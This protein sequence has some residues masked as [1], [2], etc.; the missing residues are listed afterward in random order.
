[1][2]NS[3]KTREMTP[4]ENFRELYK[5]FAQLNDKVSALLNPAW[6]SEMGLIP[7]GHPLYEGEK[8]EETQE[9]D[10]PVDWRAVVQ[11]RERDLKAVGEAQQKAVEERDDAYRER[12]QLLAW[13]ATLF[14]PHAVLAPSL[15]VD[16]ED[17]WWL[18]FLTIAGRQMSW[19][20]S[21]RD[22]DLFQH[23]QR[24][25]S[26]DLRAQWDGH[27]TEEKYERIRTMPWGEMR[28][29]VYR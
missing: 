22:I 7:T 23:V 16:D 4:D 20:I 27:T 14:R 11:R 26:A 21:P 8:P 12:A 2:P 9:Q 18:L 3:Q 28:A 6:G 15:D 1:M 10:A 17:G 29:Y 5:R 24:V 19:H 13:I 25:D